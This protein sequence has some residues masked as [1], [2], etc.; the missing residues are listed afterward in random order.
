MC[1]VN[2]RFSIRTSEFQGNTLVNIC[3]E[4]LIGKTIAEGKLRMHI[5]RDFFYGEVVD[6]EEAL[7][8]MKVC[9]IIN[10][11]G[12]RSVSLAI[13]NKLGAR[14]AIREIENV[15]FLMIYKFLR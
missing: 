3:D 8:L 12:R 4:E 9:S 7:R 5:S 1:E 15:P 13:D 10:L 2:E 11:A 14:E 6:G